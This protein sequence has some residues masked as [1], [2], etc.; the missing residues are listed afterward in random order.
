MHGV[1]P[2]PTT[3]DTNTNIWDIGDLNANSSISMNID[4]TINTF[5]EVI[6]TAEISPSD[7]PDPN[8]SPGNNNPNEDDQDSASV[9]I[10]QADLSLDKDET[11]GEPYHLGDSVTFVLTLNNGGLDAA[12]NVTVTDLLPAGIDYVS[13]RPAKELMT[14]RPAYGIL[15]ATYL[16]AAARR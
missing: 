4:C 10:E 1:S 13:V 12:T 16:P 9:Q 8:S 15:L 3:F 5:D 2:N 7:Q 11:T 6:N 14:M